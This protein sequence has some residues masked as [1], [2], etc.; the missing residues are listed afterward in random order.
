MSII[1]NTSIDLEALPISARYT[2]HLGVAL[3]IWEPTLTQTTLVLVQGQT[4]ITFELPAPAGS[5]PCRITSITPQTEDP[6]KL[7]ITTTNP[8]LS[9]LVWN[10]NG[11]IVAKCGDDPLVSYLP[12]LPFE[13]LQFFPSRP[14]Q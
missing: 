6:E 11:N 7:V 9:W 8:A 5:K 4:P 2:S 1:I 3:G 14:T 12:P 13:L 10:H